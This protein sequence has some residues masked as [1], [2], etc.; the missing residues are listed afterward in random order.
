MTIVFLMLVFLFG[1][2]SCVKEE[3][4]QIE[5]VKDR[6]KLPGLEATKITTVISDSGITRYR[7]YTDQWDIYDRAKAPYWDFPKGIYFEKFTS[8]F[9]ID[10]NFRSDKARYDEIKR[11]W[12]FKGKVKAVNLKGEMF[13]TDLLYWDQTTERIYSDKFIRVTQ[14]TRIINAVG[15][16]SDQSLIKYRFRNVEGIMTV[17]E[18]N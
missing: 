6:T 9:A 1:A 7:I 18:T 4:V 12:E 2:I 10:A 14:Q 17:K 11:I 3:V 13:E 16:E 5:A 15:F 8:N